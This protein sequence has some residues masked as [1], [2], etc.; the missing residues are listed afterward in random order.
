[1]SIDDSVETMKPLMLLVLYFIDKVSVLSDDFEYFSGS[2]FR[3]MYLGRKPT[4]GLDF[5][6]GSFLNSINNGQWVEQ[7]ESRKKFLHLLPKFQ[8][9]FD[10]TK[11]SKIKKNLPQTCVL[12][13]PMPETS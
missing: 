3:S 11:S 6:E 12:F 9:I 10:D 4:S 5:V 13:N 7:V 8:V 1:M 2:N